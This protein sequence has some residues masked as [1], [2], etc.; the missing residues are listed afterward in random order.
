MESAFAGFF[1]GG[2]R[3]GVAAPVSSVFR[4]AREQL[5]QVREDRAYS[6]LREEQY[7]PMSGMPIPETEKQLETQ[8]KQLK[9][10]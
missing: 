5:Q 3:A 8:I 1:A 10:G 4:T 9:E 2:A 7:G 6:N